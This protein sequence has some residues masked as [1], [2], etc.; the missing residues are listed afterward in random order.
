MIMKR[1]ASE[2]K[3]YKSVINETID[4]EGDEHI[5]DINSN[6]IEGNDFG[7]KSP[8]AW[9]QNDLSEL[10]EILD[11][12]QR[13][14]YEIKNARRGS[15]GLDGDTMDDLIQKMEE[16]GSR[17]TNLAKEYMSKEGKES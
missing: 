14:Q 2:I 17:L 7:I 12:A 5:S 11:D 1:L 3:A 4:S 9:D 15:Y 8:D 10:I 13:V 16:L 6:E